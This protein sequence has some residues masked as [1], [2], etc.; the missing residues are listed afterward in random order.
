MC[1]KAP[2]DTTSIV[3]PKWSVG[4]CSTNFDR[5]PASEHANDSPHHDACLTAADV[6]FAC[7]FAS[8]VPK[9]IMAVSPYNYCMKAKTV[10]APVKPILIRIGRSRLGSCSGIPP[11]RFQ[12]REPGFGRVMYQSF[13]TSRKISHE[14]PRV[15]GSFPGGFWGPL[16]D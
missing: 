7:I 9:N 14:C 2:P 10:F 1:G 11:H 3:R 5:I 15:S 13:L 4:D 6:M 16:T 8:A 12:S